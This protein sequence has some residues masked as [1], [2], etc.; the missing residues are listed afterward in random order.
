MRGFLAKISLNLD[1]KELLKGSSIALL[2]KVFGAF[3]GYLFFWVL[4]KYFGANGVGIF[5]T[6]WTLLMVSAVVSKFGFD[7]SI[8]KYIASFISGGKSYLA[9]KIYG[10]CLGWI[11][12][13]GLIVT[14]A[15]LSF[16]KELSLIFFENPADKNL[17]IITAFCI[18]PVSLLGYNAESLKGMKKITLF[19]LFQNSTI[20]LVALLVIMFFYH[21]RHQSSVIIP[22]SLLM[23]T[24]I[25][26][27]FSFLA[28]GKNIP[29]SEK[30][31]ALRY[32]S[33][34]IFWVTFPMLLSNSLFLIMNWTDT[35][36]L[37]AFR[38]EAEVGVY[39]TSMKI[40]ALNSI[41]LVA[42]NSI[43]MPKFAELYLRKDR[44]AFKQFVKQTTFLMFIVSFPV[45]LIIV[46]FPGFL[47]SIFGEEFRVGIPALLILASGQFFSAISGST[48]HI[49]NMTGKEKTARN[50][51][52]F[53]T[54]V[55]I[56]LNFYLIPLYGIIGAAIATAFSTILWNILSVVYIYKYFRF[57]TYPI[58]LK[59]GFYEKP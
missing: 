28:V 11:I 32:K 51:L 40:A 29:A 43:A 36:M 14:I 31:R 59:F 26:M 25:I 56:M 13:I 55:N 33:R 58:P 49:L 6:L 18:L 46:L 57:L 53:S 1:L 19:S 27:G 38:S 35:L 2:F 24:I 34:H 8:V 22:Y 7:T 21:L 23:A 17:F 42:V 41:I 15:V 20:Y 45:L 5:S 30:K 47:L 54:L 12:G 48:I 9:Q 44:Q 52:L 39:N 4:A 50:I 3:I 10:K 16:S 37:S